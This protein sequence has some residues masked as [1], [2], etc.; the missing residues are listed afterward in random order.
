M[1]G[2]HK[3]TPSAQQAADETAALAADQERNRTAGKGAPTPTRKQQ[4]AARRR[5]LVPTDRK[6]ATAAA[7][8]ADR[9]ERA[10]VRQA[11]DTGDE[12]YLPI[13]DKGPQRRFARAYVDSRWN[14][15]EFLMFAAV[16]FVILSLVVPVSSV[17]QVYVL[18]AFWIL[19]IAVFID[20]FI[21]FRGL[22]KALVAKF[23][24]AER[25]V[26]WYGTMRAMQFR[27]L[28]LPKPQ[29]KRG[30]RPS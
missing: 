20:G 2:R 29:V 1:F 17:G 12:R 24:V 7:R 19:F 9:A 21:V 10:K 18:G 28:R 26:P 15:G 30:D 3:E 8:E 16:L 27:R 13:R 4:E 14:L 25:G 5:P 11:L 22:R 23:G 6:A